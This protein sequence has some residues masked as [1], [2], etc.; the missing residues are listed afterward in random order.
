MKVLHFYK[1]SIFID[2]CY[3]GRNN[4]LNA[5]NWRLWVVISLK[6]D[7]EILSFNALWTYNDPVRKCTCACKDIVKQHTL[8]APDTSESSYMH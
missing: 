3:W 5:S 6:M 4:N 1:K 8:K 7:F 2:C